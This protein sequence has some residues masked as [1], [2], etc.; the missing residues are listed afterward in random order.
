LKMMMKEHLVLSID[1]LLLLDTL[2]YMWEWVHLV[3]SGHEIGCG[4]NLDGIAIMNVLCQERL[5]P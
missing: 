2:W 4:R 3:W 5:S 1:G